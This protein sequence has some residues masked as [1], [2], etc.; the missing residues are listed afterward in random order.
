MQGAMKFANGITG[1]SLHFNECHTAANQWL[2]F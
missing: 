2:E 1:N